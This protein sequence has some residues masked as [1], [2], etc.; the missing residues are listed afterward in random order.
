MLNGTTELRIEVT[1]DFPPFP[2]CEVFQ[3]SFSDDDKFKNIMSFLEVSWSY[4]NSRIL[5]LLNKY[6]S[7]VIISYNTTRHLNEI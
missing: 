2:T 3:F 1:D 6:N 4:L 5:N 7:M